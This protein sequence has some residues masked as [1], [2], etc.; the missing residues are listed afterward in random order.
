MENFS[1]GYA[2][3]MAC[4]DA[5]DVVLS[6]LAYIE[7]HKER[8]LI[9]EKAFVGTLVAHGLTV[10]VAQCEDSSSAAFFPLRP[11][12]AMAAIWNVLQRVYSTGPPSPSCPVQIKYTG[13][14]CTIPS[15]ER[16]LRLTQEEQA[17]VASVHAVFCDDAEHPL[18]SVQRVA[19]DR[20][21]TPP[22]IEAFRLI[23]S[24]NPS[25]PTRVVFFFHQGVLDR[26]RAPSWSF[27]MNGRSGQEPFQSQWETYATHL[28][29]RLAD[30]PSG[31]PLPRDTRLSIEIRPSGLRQRTP[32]HFHQDSSPFSIL[33]SGFVY[34]HDPGHGSQPIVT[35][36]SA[37]EGGSETIVAVPIATWDDLLMFDNQHL[38]H[39]APDG[40]A[41][42]ADLGFFLRVF[43]TRAR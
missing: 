41:Q 42:E 26:T 5:I 12:G 24:T 10:D 39:R 33:R 9:P 36:F 29:A 40:L 15:Q 19:T 3:L 27:T 8:I 37:E 7:Y 4:E 21:L 6:A 20:G 38:F 14:T 11:L 31:E 13:H 30:F 43:L 23:E 17:R 18:L 25:E 1:E 32:T 2:K 22:P 34:A 28:W 35:E 16:C